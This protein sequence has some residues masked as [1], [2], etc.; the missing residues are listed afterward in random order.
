MGGD[1]EEAK[2]SEGEAPDAEATESST[3]GEAS[4][5]ECKSS[6]VRV[7]SEEEAKETDITEVGGWLFQA[8]L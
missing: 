4:N 5:A 2:P 3:E 7:L 6:I 8:R 1:S